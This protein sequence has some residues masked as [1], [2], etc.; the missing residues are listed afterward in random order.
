VSGVGDGFAWPFQDPRWFEKLIVQGLIGIIPIVG[1]IAL[2]GWLMLTVDNY[3][4]GR[5]ELPPAGFHLARGG[6]VFLVLVVYS[7]VFGLPGGAISRSGAVVD[8]AGLLSLGDLLNF[9]LWLMLSFLTPAVV[10]LTYQRGLA[11]GFDVSA[12]WEAA[13]GNV[14]NSIV[15]GLVIVAAEV[16]G[17][18][19]FLLC[20]IGLLFTIPYAAAVTA[21]VVTWYAQT[22]GGPRPVSPPAGPA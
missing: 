3:R 6:P 16:V 11:G 15:A 12:V 22:M 10:L 17:G 4:G 8:S 5:R 18:L 13:S 19:G 2:A 14:N 7:I 9:A 1:W 20:C 21:G